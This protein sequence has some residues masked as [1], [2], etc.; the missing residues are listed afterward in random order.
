M[1]S[2]PPRCPHCK[3]FACLLCPSCSQHLQSCRLESLF[4]DECRNLEGFGSLEGCRFRVLEC[5]LRPPPHL[6]AREKDVLGPRFQVWDV[7]SDA[8]FTSGGGI[9]FW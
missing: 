8:S 5:R 9:F 4:R 2:Q 3:S 7:Q 6:F 1:L